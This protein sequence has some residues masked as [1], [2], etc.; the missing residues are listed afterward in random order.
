MHQDIEPSQLEPGTVIAVCYYMYKHFAIISDRSKDGA[1]NLI[2]LSYRTRRVKEE[3]WDTVVG[4]RRIEKSLIKGAYSQ[5]IVLSRARSCMDKNITYELLTFNCEHFARY[6]HGLRIESV[7]V[8]QAI[9][10]AAFGAA[11][12]LLLSNIT[13][14]RFAMLTTAGA[15]SSLRK[16]LHKL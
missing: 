11:S 15:V 2:S 14:A 4:T 5:E 16:S 12:C 9:Y 1:P 3:P 7:Q 10:G 8:K 6:A 13:V